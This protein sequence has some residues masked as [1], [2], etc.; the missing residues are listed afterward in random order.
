MNTSDFLVGWISPESTTGDFDWVV[1]EC[2][3]YNGIDPI[4]LDESLDD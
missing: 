3:P 4:D 1:T 2:A